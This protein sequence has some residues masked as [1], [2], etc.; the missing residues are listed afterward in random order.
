[1][2]LICNSFMARDAKLFFICFLAIWIVSF[3]KALFISFAYFFI[4]SLILVEF[5]FFELLVYSGYQL[6]VSYI[7]GKDVLSLGSL[8]NLETISFLVQ[9]LFSFVKSHLLILFLSY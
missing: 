8:F 6:L 4:G 2:V 3:D 5:C 7:A 9:K 1:M